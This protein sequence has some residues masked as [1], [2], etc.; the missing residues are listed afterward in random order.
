MIVI[1]RVGKAWANAACE[2]HIPAAIV[3]ACAKSLKR[4]FMNC[5]LLPFLCRHALYRRPA[6][7]PGIYPFRVSYTTCSDPESAGGKSACRLAYRANCEEHRPGP[8]PRIGQS[9]QGIEHDE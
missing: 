9:L 1:G 5:L 6:D 3:S 7:Q 2:R 4:N 8:W